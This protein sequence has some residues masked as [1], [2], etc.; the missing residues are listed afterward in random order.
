MISKARQCSSL[1]A[2]GKRQA[3][4]PQT[5]SYQHLPK[6][7]NHIPSPQDP[8]SKL[9]KPRG[10]GAAIAHKFASEGCNLAIN[11]S[12]NAQ[13]A[14]D[15]A[16]ELQETYNTRTLTLRAD[17]G[18]LAAC[19]QLVHDTHAHFGS[20]DVL[21]A[22]AGWTKFT[23]FSDLDA[24]TEAEWDKCFAVNVK[25][26][27]ALLR[28]AVPF[29]Q[30]EGDGGVMV[31]TSS[32]AGNSLGGSSMAYSVTKAAQ[33]HLVKCLAATQGCGGRVRVNAV[34]PGLLL[35]EWGRE[36]GEERIGEINSKAVLKREVSF[37]LSFVCSRGR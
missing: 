5:T 19:A 35:T 4:H 9:R 6:T 2:Q 36:Y 32:I 28:A 14:S 3:A 37:L 24:M 1:A 23:T 12:S 34:L 10:L 18:D 16:K 8:P 26:P 29:W 30:G 20:L 25:G 7:P 33:L 17:C 21:I 11:Y 15:L 13:A 31:V 22:N 27:H